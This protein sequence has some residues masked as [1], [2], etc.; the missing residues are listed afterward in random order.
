MLQDYKKKRDFERTPEPD[1]KRE[2][3][4]AGP[5]IFVVQKHAARQ[6]HY[7]FRLEVDGVLKSWAVAKGPS[8]DAGTK[9]LA[10]MVED[11]P[12][13]YAGFEGTIPEGQY[14]AGQVII[15]DRGTY[16]PDEDGELHFEDRN[17]AEKLM[18][19]GLAGG[20]ISITLRGDK[21]KGSWTL[22]KMHKSENNWLL[23]KHHD[24][25]ADPSRDI[26]K[27]E[28]SVVSGLTV[29]KLKTGRLPPKTPSPAVKPSEIKGAVKASFPKKITPMLA[30][31]APLPFSNE[32][33]IFEPKLDGF[34]T[35][36][37][38]NSGK[39]WLQSRGELDVTAHY[40]I[41]AESL[42]KQPESQLVFDGEI[43]ALDA[44]GKLC[45]QCL[46]GYLKSI[47]GLSQDKTEAPSA[48]IYYIFD[49]L[50]LDGY[51]L[52]RV[53]LSTRK[54]LLHSVLVPAEDVRLVEHF[55]KDGQT[56][57]EAAIKNGLEGVVAKRKAG[58]YEAGKRSKDWLKIK[59]VNSDEFIIC[60]FTQGT[61][62]RSKT[63][64]ALVLGNYD[65][66]NVLLPAG[67]VGTGFDS[68]LLLSL[69]KQ[70][71][72]LSVKSTPFGT[73]TKDSEGVTWV[74]PE[75]VAE[76]KFAERTNDGLLRAPVFLR[77]RE[78]KPTREVH[79]SQI[80]EAM[81]KPAKRSTMKNT[82]K[83]DDLLA[84]LDN[85][86]TDLVLETEGQKVSLS[87]LDKEIWPAY[88][89]IKAVTKRT[90]IKYLV[91]VHVYLLPHLKDRPL[92]LS[93]YPNGI[94]GGHFFQKHYRPVPEFVET[95]ALSSNDTPE[96]EYLLCNNLATLLWLGQIADIELHTWFSRIKPGP[97]FLIKP[98]HPAKADYYADYPDFLIFDI[99]PYIYSGK[100]ASG[101]EPE[102]NRASFTKTCGVAQKVKQ[103]LDQLS[104]PSFVKTSGKT[105]LHVFIP[106]KRRL[107]FHGT[108]E[109]AEKLSKF[110]Q[111][112]YPDLIT[113]DWAVEKRKGK[114]FLDYN[115][116]VRGKT[117][118]SIYSPR[119]APGA[120][121]SVPLRW[122][123]LGGIYPTDFTIKT[124]PGRLESIGDLW[125]NIMETKIDI[126]KLF[127]TLENKLPKSQ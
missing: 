96:Q 12:L 41:L 11:H 39:V 80:V 65:K 16:S 127:S 82:K 115:Q 99:D 93:R 46:Q 78:D 35:L 124:V 36:A 60:G 83:Q 44:K 104:C 20:K 70:L 107:D 15:W 67:N 62:N 48:I 86:E 9:R 87:H 24:E 42:R 13:E 27:A 74:R 23:I 38:L 10:V 81:Q 40:K 118:A 121:V 1:F 114:V 43:I 100:E 75:L 73:K 85:K 7:D 126:V 21:M 30:S 123:E 66:N 102:L 122:D 17:E 55:E 22:V 26:L 101:E 90:L 32:Q 14:G 8:L 95:V 45:F 34:R 51:D 68:G 29:N 112:Q 5:L 59:A 125:A 69:R 71:N 58:I 4:K 97:D 72:S 119:P 64:G 88:P 103:I 56:V 111:Q 52:M 18:R 50:Y 94:E 76:V 77:L 31:L 61:G 2:K 3:A 108:H 91:E 25:Y 19:K 63:F 106:I 116:N 54:E 6:L 37:F 98:K 84:Q 53:P 113:T 49:I 105:G 47:K 109:L 89:G 57:Y 92:S 33:W 120:T 110:L 28:N 79:P 117:L